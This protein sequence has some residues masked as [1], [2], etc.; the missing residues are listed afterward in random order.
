MRADRATRRRRTAA[1]DAW[2]RRAPCARRR[3]REVTPVAVSLCVANTA[4]ISCALSAARIS[5]YISTGTPVPHSSSS[6]ST[7]RPR[8]SAMSTHSM[9]ELAEAAHQHLVAAVQ[10]VG[11][12]RL[13]GAGAGRGED[14]DAAVREL[15]H[16]L[17]V[18]EQ[19]QRELGEFRRAHVFHADVH[20]RA[21]G[22]GDVG[23]AGNEQMRRNEHEVLPP[24][25]RLI[26]RFCSV[27]SLRAFCADPAIAPGDG[28]VVCCLRLG[29]KHLFTLMPSQHPIGQPLDAVG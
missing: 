21:D 12:R 29:V 16:L 27:R 17:D 4:L 18:L 10:R 3:R 7:L 2:R 26:L 8:R 13:P 1:R 28:S 9:R 6:T 5:A 23:R 11:D 25:C 24:N 20:R 14:E 15:E 22:F 19:R